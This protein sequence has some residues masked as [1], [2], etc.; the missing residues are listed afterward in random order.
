MHWMPRSCSID[1]RWV[2]K[3]EPR[4]IPKGGVSGTLMVWA[5]RR[6]MLRGFR[7]ANSRARQR[8]LMER[9]V[10]TEHKACAL[11][12]AGSLDASLLGIEIA[13]AS[14]GG[15]SELNDVGPVILL[16]VDHDP[17]LP[18]HRHFFLPHSSSASRFTA[19]AFAFFILSQS[20]ER[21]ER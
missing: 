10:Q 9:P 5:I 20:G 6:A 17:V 7:F 14:P 13:S 19:G 2:P 16:P 11:G 15:R 18:R 1:A 4:P 8:F 3:R 21:R 12:N